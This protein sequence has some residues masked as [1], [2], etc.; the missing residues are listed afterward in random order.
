MTTAAAPPTTFPELTYAGR[1]FVHVADGV[2]RRMTE[3]ERDALSES[4]GAYGIRQALHVTEDGRVG[5]GW[6]RLALAADLGL[7]WADVAAAV[8]W[9]PAA[10]TDAQLRALSYDLN[11]ARRH[12]APAERRAEVRRR[13][14]AGESFRAIGAALG[15]SEATARGDS[16]TAQPCAVETVVGRDGKARPAGRP[17]AAAA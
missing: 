15:V 5:D 12:L 2:V 16:S 3:A 10:T 13:R 14:G 11:H 1:R 6:N 17:D 9:L 8:A 4:I 7:P